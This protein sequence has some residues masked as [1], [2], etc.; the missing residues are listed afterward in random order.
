MNHNVWTVSR[1]YLAIVYF[2]FLSNIFQSRKKSRLVC[3]KSESN[4]VILLYLFSL[5]ELHRGQ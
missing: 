4:G 3:Q 1:V 2:F 5:S